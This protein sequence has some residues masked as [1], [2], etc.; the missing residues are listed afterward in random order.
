MSVSPNIKNPKSSDFKWCYLPVIQD[1]IQKE[2]SVNVSLVKY[3]LSIEY[4]RS[5]IGF[6]FSN[7]LVFLFLCKHPNQLTHHNMHK[8]EPSFAL[9]DH[10]LIEFCNWRTYELDPKDSFTEVINNA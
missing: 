3:I 6:K 1:N 4:L 5:C 8:S 7:N 10:L 2:Q 9:I